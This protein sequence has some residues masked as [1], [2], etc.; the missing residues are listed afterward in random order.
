M[1]FCRFVKLMYPF[2]KLNAR[3]FF[4]SS[5]LKSLQE[6]ENKIMETLKSVDKCNKSKLNVNSTFVDIGLDSLD[7]VELVCA[8]EDIFEIDLP[9]DEALKIVG[10]QD[11]TRIFNSYLS[12][13]ANAQHQKI[14]S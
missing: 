10:V 8:L 5:S 12:K 7:Q 3:S 13:K 4:A 11:A 2:V 6:I 1:N 9:H 14:I